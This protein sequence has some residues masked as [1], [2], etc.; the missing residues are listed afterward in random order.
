MPW[1]SGWQPEARGGMFVLSE[2]EHAARF[3]LPGFVLTDRL[4]TPEGADP[5]V[6]VIRVHKA[7]RRV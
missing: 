6:L 7:Q 2:R 3:S 1:K 4:R 5:T